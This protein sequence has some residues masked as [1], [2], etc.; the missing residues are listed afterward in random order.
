MTFLEM[1]MK[2]LGRST[3]DDTHNT[4]SLIRTRQL[5]LRHLEDGRSLYGE[6]V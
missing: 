5:C 3:W 6:G 2:E 1:E 4:R